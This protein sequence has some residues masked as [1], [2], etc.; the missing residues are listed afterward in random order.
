MSKVCSKLSSEQ[1]FE[2]K[3]ITSLQKHIIIGSFLH[4]KSAAELPQSLN[5]TS[6]N[7]RQIRSRGLNK[8]RSYLL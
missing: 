7:V 2:Q 5:L 8:V 3:I 4:Q 6:E 1:S